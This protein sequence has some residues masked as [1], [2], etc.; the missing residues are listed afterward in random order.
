MKRKLVKKL[1]KSNDSTASE[2]TNCDKLN[3][4]KELLH[5]SVFVKFLYDFDC[6]SCSSTSSNTKNAKDKVNSFERQRILNLISYKRK[7]LASG[8][9]Y[10][11]DE[12]SSKSVEKIEENCKSAN[13]IACDFVLSKFQDFVLT[14][15]TN[16][17]INYQSSMVSVDRILN[18]TR[19]VNGYTQGILNNTQEPIDLDEEQCELADI[20]QLKFQKLKQLYN[21]NSL[22][23]SSNTSR[24]RH[25]QD[26]QFVLVQFLTM[27]NNWKLRKFTLEIDER[28]LSNLK[29]NLNKSLFIDSIISAL[30]AYECLSNQPQGVLDNCSRTVEF[31]QKFKLNSHSYNTS[32]YLVEKFEILLYDWVLSAQTHVWTKHRLCKVELF[33]QSL[34]E[35][36]NFLN[37]YPQL[38]YKAKMYETI[39]MFCSNRNPVNLINSVAKQSVFSKSNQEAFLTMNSILKKFHLH[40]IY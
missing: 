39:L 38:N 20:D 30:K 35:F 31:I 29:V 5:E 24:N 23:F 10:N 6:S 28:T 25:H 15:M 4:L 2:T 17:I 40:T 37:N 11:V 22:Y 14:K 3:S 36:Q 21:L 33:N 34:R 9:L 18:A 8:Y 1:G 7:I 27:L 32:N 12:D 13:G 26:T 16:H 19:N